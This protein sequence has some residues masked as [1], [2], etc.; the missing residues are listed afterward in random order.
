[1]PLQI[2][3]GVIAPKTITCQTCPLRSN[4]QFDRKDMG[5][6]KGEGPKYI[7]FRLI[8]DRAENN[9]ATEDIMTCFNFV[10]S[11][12]KRMRFG[13]QQRDEGK[14]GEVVR[15]IKQEGETI[16][17]R[18][19]CGFNAKG[20]IVRPNAEIIPELQAAG[21]KITKDD[22]SIAI[23]WKDVVYEGKVPFYQEWISKNSGYNDDILSR[24]RDTEEQANELEDAAWAEAERRMAAKE[25]KSA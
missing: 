15:V 1:M 25:K 22:A 20:E 19:H 23:A 5:G 4:C 6:F 16:K 21:H 17:K 12:Q 2:N 8:T 10:E 18:A 13:R 14:D 11:L 7:G 3:R 9:S 24:E